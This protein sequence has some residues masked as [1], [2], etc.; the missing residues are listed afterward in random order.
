MVEP[1]PANLSVGKHCTW[2]TVSRSS[3]CYEHKGETSMNFNLKRLSGNGSAGAKKEPIYAACCPTFGE[4]LNGPVSYQ[5]KIRDR[6]VF[7]WFRPGHFA[8]FRAIPVHRPSFLSAADPRPGQKKT[9][10]FRLP[11][12]PPAAPPRA[13]FRSG[14]IFAPIPACRMRPAAFEQT[15]H[16]PQMAPQQ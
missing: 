2:L 4:Q 11:G 1:G 6:P 7:I 14:W 15:N 10:P 3:F 16:L 13:M 9:A 12:Q 5:R 8:F